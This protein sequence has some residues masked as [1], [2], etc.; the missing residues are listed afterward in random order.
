MY[1]EL[2]TMLQKWDTANLFSLLLQDEGRPCPE[3]SAS[4]SI[5]PATSCTTQVVTCKVEIRAKVIRACHTWWKKQDLRAAW[6]EVLTALP[7][8]MFL[9]RLWHTAA[10]SVWICPVQAF[11]TWLHF[12]FFVCTCHVQTSCRAQ[13]TSAPQVTQVRLGSVEWCVCT[14]HS[15]CTIQCFHQAH[16]SKTGTNLPLALNVYHPFT[17]LTNCLNDEPL[18]LYS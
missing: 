10:A 7:E 16:N 1:H 4:C 2:K 18:H 9:I 14:A 8:F 11:C 3:L 15:N 6:E 13:Q 5:P 17:V 12:T